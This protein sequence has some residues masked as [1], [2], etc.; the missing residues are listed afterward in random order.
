M[1]RIKFYHR[2]IEENIILFLNQSLYEVNLGIRDKG[3]FRSVH[4]ISSDLNIDKERVTYICD[5]SK[6]IRRNTKEKTSWTLRKYG[7]KQP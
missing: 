2:C 4:A 1:L 7:V 3:T 5:N 6:Y